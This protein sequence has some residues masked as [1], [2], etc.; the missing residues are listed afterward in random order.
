MERIDKRRKPD[1]LGALGARID[2][3]RRRR[4]KPGP[5]PERLWRA[6]AKLAAKH[7]VN[8]VA[9]ALQGSAFAGGMLVWALAHND[10]A[11]PG[12]TA[13]YLGIHVTLAGIR[14]LAAPLAGATLYS[15]IEALAP[16]H[17]AWALAAPLALVSLGA[18]GF[19][20]LARVSRRDLE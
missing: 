16:G 8:R 20:R 6:A 4:G 11:P 3:W 13:E 7:G 10:F 9:A 18:L 15:G 1:S 2:R 19:G 12:R 17:G 5:M 14:G